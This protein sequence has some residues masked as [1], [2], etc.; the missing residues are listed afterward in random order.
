[1]PLIACF[2]VHVLI[3]VLA[4]L[5]V[6]PFTCPAESRRHHAVVLV[7]MLSYV[8]CL[9]GAQGSQAQVIVSTIS[10]ASSQETQNI[11]NTLQQSVNSGQFA[12]SLRQSGAQL[13]VCRL[14]KPFEYKQPY[15]R[16]C[17]KMITRRLDSNLAHGPKSLLCII[18]TDLNRP[19]GL[20]VNG[21][22]LGGSSP[23]SSPAAQSPPAE[24]PGSPPTQAPAQP[25]AASPSPALPQPPSP[26]TSGASASGS[27]A[28][29]SGGGG[30]GG[31]GL[32][33]I[34]G[35]AVGAAAAIILAGM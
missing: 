20:N 7:A 6:T 21:V 12:N 27:S 5:R 23:S 28:P 13:S 17:P 33:A 3:F 26:Q 15:S 29:P 24:S 4:I 30:S 19:A 9:Q 16:A 2:C 14:L 35:I 18:V 22:S 34:I 8:C 10:G 32:G 25:P 1:M 31:L 11:S